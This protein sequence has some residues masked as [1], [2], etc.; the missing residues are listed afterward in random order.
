M[1]AGGVSISSAFRWLVASEVGSVLRPAAADMFCRFP[2]I[3]L[4]DLEVQRGGI[5]ENHLH[6]E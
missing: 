6:V 2:A 5:V 1:A 3:L 4:V